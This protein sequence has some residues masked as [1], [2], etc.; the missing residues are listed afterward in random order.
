MISVLTMRIVS[1]IFTAMLCMDHNSLALRPRAH[2]SEAQG[3]S[4]IQHSP[5]YSKS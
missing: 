2:A 4:C 1:T 3:L 5:H